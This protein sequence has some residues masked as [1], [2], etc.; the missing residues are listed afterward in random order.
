MV[1][2]PRQ[3]ESAERT[4]TK[5]TKI[6]DYAEPRRNGDSFFKKTKKTPWLRSSVYSAISVRSV[7]DSSVPP[8]ISDVS[9]HP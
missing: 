4:G 9:H 3:T 2:N 6:A 1:S 5:D 7:P 8:A